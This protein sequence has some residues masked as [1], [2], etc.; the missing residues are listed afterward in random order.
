LP[1][2]NKLDSELPQGH[3]QTPGGAA[4][5]R[6]RFL[7]ALAVLPEGAPAGALPRRFKQR[8][9]AEAATPARLGR[10]PAM[11][12]PAP[13]YQ[14]QPAWCRR[15]GQREREHAHVARAAT[16]QGDASELAQELRVVV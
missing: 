12:G 8:V 4:T 3:R 6:D 15:V 1:A 14:A 16:L 5:M 2:S 9:V 7:L 10:D 13:G 11:R